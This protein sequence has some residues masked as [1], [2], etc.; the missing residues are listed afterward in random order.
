MTL[1]I[2]LLRAHNVHYRLRGYVEEYRF[3]V[4]WDIP[5]HLP[6]DVFLHIA[7][8][9]D[10]AGTKRVALVSSSECVGVSVCVRE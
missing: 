8:R 1:H 2:K 7:A 6:T 9:A 10:P 4:Q 3:L 5:H